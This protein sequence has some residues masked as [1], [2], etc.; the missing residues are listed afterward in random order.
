MVLGMVWGGLV[1]P[2][3]SAQFKISKVCQV[4]LHIP[5]YSPTFLPIHPHSSL[6]SN[7][8]IYLKVRLIAPQNIIAKGT[9]FIYTAL[10]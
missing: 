6:F 7:F 9:L 2:T 5:T 4:I 3:K 8:K 10:V 1:C